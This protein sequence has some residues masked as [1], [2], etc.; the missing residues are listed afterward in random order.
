LQLDT[1]TGF[2][3]GRPA[4]RGRYVFYLAAKDELGASRSLKVS[5]VIRP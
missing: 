2:I 3:S 5:I 4:H 1:T